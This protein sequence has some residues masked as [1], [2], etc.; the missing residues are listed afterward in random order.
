MTNASPVAWRNLLR[1]G[2]LLVAVFVVCL[3]PARAD[4]FSSLEGPPTK[5]DIATARAAGIVIF[6]FD[7]DKEGAA[8]AVA[9]VKKAGGRITAYHVGGGGGRAWGS[10]KSGEW[11]RKYDSPRDFLALTEDVKRLVRLGADYIHF[12][13]THRFSGVRLE[14]IVDAIRAGGAGF[15][16]KNNA[17]KWNL[18]MK[19]RPDLKPVY[20]VIEDA[21][22]DAEETQHAAN[23]AIR[24][25]PVYIIGFKLPIEATKYPVTDAYALEY[26][27]NNPWARVLVMEDERSY[28]SRTGA[29]VR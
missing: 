16:A 18:V 3:A 1:A 2:A 5:T 28:D 20:A 19:R 6:E 29:Y 11:L 17:A 21:M 4:I 24:G 13:N 10:V 15:V 7:L 9:A 25:V 27:R 12:D 14:S 8:E 26:A 23:L 22:F